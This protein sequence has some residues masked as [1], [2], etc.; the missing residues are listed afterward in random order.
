MHDEPATS[1]WLPLDPEDHAAQLAAVF[2]LAQGPPRAARILD[3]GAGTG[4]VAHP[5]AQR[6]HQVVALDNN[7][8]AMEHL[9]GENITPVLG[10]ALSPALDLASLGP[11]DGALCL[12]HTFMLFHDVAQALHLM[13]RVRSALRPSGGGWFAID[14]FAEQVW[15]DIADG[16]WQT[17]LSEDDQWQ[18]IWSGNDNT[19]VIRHG[20]QVRPHDWDIG[21][22]DRLLRL[23][24]PGEL[25]L[26]AAS[27]GFGPPRADH[28]GAL[29]VF[30]CA[31]P[32]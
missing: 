24:T 11:F 8:A 5:L 15:R 10:D 32:A 6:G 13:R 30:P 7:D 4:R 16:D 25:A 14:N 1:D 18:F 12:G 23:W 28:T 21:P 17:G 9:A 29:L 2:L 22:D 27:A 20:D 3:I 19:A 26:L 31:A